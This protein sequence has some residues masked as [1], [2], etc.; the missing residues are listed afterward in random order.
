MVSGHLQVKKGF[1]YVDVY[2]R[3]TLIR[4]GATYE[5]LCQSAGKQITWFMGLPVLVAAVSSLLGVRALFTPLRL[6]E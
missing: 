3:Q 5:T 2:K 4:L 6:D 1:Y